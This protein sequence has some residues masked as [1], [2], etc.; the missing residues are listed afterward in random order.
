MCASCPLPSSRRSAPP[1]LLADLVAPNRAW[2]KASVVAAD[3]AAHR[4]CGNA[5]HVAVWSACGT[6]PLDGS[7]SEL[8]LRGYEHP[9]R[10]MLGASN[11]TPKSFPCDPV[12]AQ[13]LGRSACQCG[14]HWTFGLP[15]HL[16]AMMVAIRIMRGGP[17]RIMEN[18]MYRSQDPTPAERCAC[19]CLISN[20]TP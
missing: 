15:K 3:S 7:L 10:S 11:D 19:W 4:C 2:S 9:V 8:P 6:S 16:G 17:A 18:P 12:K 20:I 1:L 13:A 14:F 5:K